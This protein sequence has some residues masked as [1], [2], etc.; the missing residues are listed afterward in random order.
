MSKFNDISWR[1][2]D[3]EIDCES[4]AK[5]VSLFARRLGAGQWSFIG[6]GSEKRWYTI[7]EDSP[8][9]EKEQSYFF[10]Q[11]SLV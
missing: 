9:G 2:K 10:M 11:R 4:H 8:Q 7:S 5:L 3:N 6:F 1:S